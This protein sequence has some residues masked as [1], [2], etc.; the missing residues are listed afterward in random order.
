MKEG[1]EIEDKN[2]EVWPTL[3][4]PAESGSRKDIQML[5]YCLLVVQPRHSPPISW[6]LICKSQVVMRITSQCVPY[7]LCTVTFQH[8]AGAVVLPLVDISVG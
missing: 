7:S 5:L 8:I 4:L 1:P 6:L 2:P 3:G